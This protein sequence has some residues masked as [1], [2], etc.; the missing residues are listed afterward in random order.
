[1]TFYLV[2]KHQNV[3]SN[4]V[5]TMVKRATDS[6]KAGHSGTLDPFATGLL[7]IATNEDTKFLQRFLKEKKTYKGLIKFGETTDTLDIDGKVTETKDSDV[8]LVDLEEAIGSKFVGRISQIPPNYSAA[9]VNGKKAYELAREGKEI[10]LDPVER[11]IY[12][13]IVKEV[14]KN[15]FEFVVEVSSGTYI[16]ALAR[17]LGEALDT[18]TMIKKLERTNIGIYSIEDSTDLDNL[19]PIENVDFVDVKIVTISD[20]LLKSVLDGKTIKL[21]SAEPEVLVMNDDRST[22][23]LLNEVEGTGTFKIRKRIR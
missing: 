23:I 14:E 17:D 12:K 2:N 7:I 15:L 8:K 3:T 19:K 6:A 16:R 4:D 10:T 9:R 1:M 18:P 21:K 11:F 5:V 22:M 20:D 13:F